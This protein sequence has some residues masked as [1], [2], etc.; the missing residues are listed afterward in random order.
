MRRPAAMATIPPTLQH[1][2]LHV[3]GYKYQ[4]PLGRKFCNHARLARQLTPAEVHD[5]VS[6]PCACTGRHAAYFHAHGLISSD[7]GNVISCSADAL[8]PD[9]PEG[10]R[11]LF[12]HGPKHRP[13]A[14]SL[15]MSA[16]VRAQIYRDLKAGFDAYQRQYADFQPWCAAVLQTF[17]Q[18][19]YHG[20]AFADGKVLPCKNKPNAACSEFTPWLPCY[21]GVISEVHEQ[22]VITTADKLQNNYVVVC[23]KHYLQKI[24]AYL[25]S[26]QFY[27]EQLA[28]AGSSVIDGIVDS[29]VQ[30]VQTLVPD[31]SLSCRTAYVAEQA[32]I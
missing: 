3:V 12:C 19:L 27:Q 24:V 8:G 5:I 4:Q 14:L 1:V 2:P 6:R 29:L 9:C 28:A 17:T 25:G 15:T 23:M 21:D 11:K 20:A 26:G 7:C 16:S 22:F 10:L 32:T 31:M 13:M 18:Q 30:Q